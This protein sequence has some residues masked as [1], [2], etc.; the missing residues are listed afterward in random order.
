MPD[1]TS[2]QTLLDVHKLADP[3]DVGLAWYWLVFGFSAQSLFMSRLLLQWIASERAKRSIVPPAF[4]WIS[5]I[6][7]AL[8]FIYFLRRGDPVGMVG[9][10]FGCVVYLRNLIFL[11]RADRCT[12]SQQTP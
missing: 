2:I 1:G 3:R 6:G 11:R 12:E 9:Q 4:W 7:G 10:G 5:L 8:L